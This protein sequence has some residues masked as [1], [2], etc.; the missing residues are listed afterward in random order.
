MKSQFK[1]A[2]SGSPQSASL[3]A[4]LKEGSSDVESPP[5]AGFLRFKGLISNIQKLY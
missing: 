2:Y 1:F 3:A 4:P 5:V